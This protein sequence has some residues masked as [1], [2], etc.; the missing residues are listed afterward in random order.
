MNQTQITMEQK[1]KSLTEQI[2]IS[3]WQIREIEAKSQNDFQEICL[4]MEQEINNLSRSNNE[5]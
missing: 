2:E 1:V 4:T 5:L 3:H